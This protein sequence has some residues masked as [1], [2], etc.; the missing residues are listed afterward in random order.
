M[1][2]AIYLAIVFCIFL[3]PHSF[4][5]FG[6]MDIAN[7]SDPLLPNPDRPGCPL[8]VVAPAGGRVTVFAA[9][10][11]FNIPTHFPVSGSISADV[12]QVENDPTVSPPVLSM[13]C[14]D[15]NI[16]SGGPQLLFVTNY[17][18]G[19]HVVTATFDRCDDFPQEWKA[20]LAIY[21]PPSVLPPGPC[22][23]ALIDPVN[24]TPKLWLN[25]QL[26]SRPSDLAGAVGSVQGVAADGV[27]KI[28][29]RI[30]ASPGASVNVKLVDGSGG[31]STAADEIGGLTGVGGGSPASTVSLTASDDG[32]GGY[33][34][35]LYQ[36]PLNFVRASV[37]SGDSGAVARNVQLQVSCSDSSGTS[38]S[39][40]TVEIVRPPG[41]AHPWTLVVRPTSVAE[42]RAGEKRG[43]KSL[44]CP[45]IQQHF[46]C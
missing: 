8:V 41:G 44:E 2:K 45:A 20:S 15:R 9:V 22:S 12:G 43:K 24:S 34:Y 10:T 42:L 37:P 7:D 35:A 28:L 29:L 30:S 32:Y 6:C 18:P 26:L 33:A 38:N 27:A 25:S 13:S 16:G 39:Q 17:T 36:A 23:P 31:N 14:Q 21:V 40:T 3:T 11:V 4:G 46:D 5:Q 19:L 1:T